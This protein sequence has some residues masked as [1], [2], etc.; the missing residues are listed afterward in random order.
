MKL[1]YIN[2]GIPFELLMYIDGNFETC[3]YIYDL[4][5]FPFSKAFEI[6]FG[7]FG[8]AATEPLYRCQPVNYFLSGYDW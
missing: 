5:V 1:Y 4:L 7:I 8:R 2:I 3:V 6:S